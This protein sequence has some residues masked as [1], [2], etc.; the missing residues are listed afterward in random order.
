[1]RRRRRIVSDDHSSAPLIA[2]VA[3]G[4]AGVALGVLL[5]HK[6]GGVAGIKKRLRSVLGKGGAF[7]LDAMREFADEAFA[8]AQEFDY[9]WGE[10][11][12][13]SASSEGAVELEAR[14]LAA[15]M[16][17][18]ILSLRAVDIGAT[19]DSVIELAGW[20]NSKS[21]RMRATAIARRVAGVETVHNELLVGDPD[22][23]EA[24]ELKERV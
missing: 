13:E 3:G 18:P 12:V 16:A 23:I 5:A 8:G 10:E 21:E 17:D 15:F 7:D 1:M 20:V 11:E 22:T 24:E 14:V 19:S 9:E 6:L 4:L 2:A